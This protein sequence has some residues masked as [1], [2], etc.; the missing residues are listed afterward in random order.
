MEVEPSFGASESRAMASL[1]SEPLEEAAPAT[2][3]VDVTV[4]EFWDCAYA[5]VRF[6]GKRIVRNTAPVEI[7]APIEFIWSSINCVVQTPL[8]SA[9]KPASN[10]TR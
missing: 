7:T 3:L 1:E 5:S 10:A 4:A 6:E 8:P 9:R 2:G